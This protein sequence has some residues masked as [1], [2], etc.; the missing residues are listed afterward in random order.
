M[1]AR[2]REH[3]IKFGRICEIIKREVERELMREAQ[4]SGAIKEH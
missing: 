2:K 3:E 4:A 1:G